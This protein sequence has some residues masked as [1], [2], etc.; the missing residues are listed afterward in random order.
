[1]IE[2][3]GKRSK[4]KIFPQNFKG[5]VTV[6]IIIAVL[7]I[8]LGVLLYMFWPKIISTVSSETKNPASYI[9]QCMTEEIEDTIENIS[10]QGGSVNPEAYYM[11]ENNRIE[12]LCYTNQYFRPCVVQRPLLLQ[13]IK[14]EILKEIEEETITCFDL[15]EKSYTT[16][17]YEV[18]MKEG[19]TTVEIVP[20]KIITTF[21]YTV[22][23]TK[24]ETEKY[25]D[26]NIVLNNNLYQLVNIADS[27][28]D[29]ENIYG[30]SETTIYMDY[31]HDLK[32]QKIKQI[33]ESTIYILTNKNDDS[34]FQFA[35]R[36]YA[37]PPG[38]Y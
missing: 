27:I 8:A 33:D 1:M 17:G 25:Q 18:D 23:L 21:N 7:I 28:I 3:G 4:L 2:K 12:Y 31:Y 34:K 15:L 11:Y 37:F 6:F 5:Q 36:S 13:H 29:F 35:S 38:Y 26:F 32:V 9:Q 20:N 14:S 24:G 22:T 16:K 10:L 30:D 19:N